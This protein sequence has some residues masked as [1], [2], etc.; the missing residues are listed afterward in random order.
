MQASLDRIAAT[1]GVLGYLL[2][3]PKDGKLLHHHGME[4]IAAEEATDDVEVNE[5]FIEEV[6]ES[7]CEPLLA[8]LDRCW[9]TIRELD[10]TNEVVNLR[11][12]TVKYEIFIYPDPAKQDFV[13][14]TF[15][16]LE[17]ASQ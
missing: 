6:A 16:H 7:F 15:Q 4:S 11:I 3:H 17:Q 2:F 1:K 14:V 5:A 13:F 8:F 12:R 9:S 10:A